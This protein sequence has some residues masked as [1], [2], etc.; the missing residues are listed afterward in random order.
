M[1]GPRTGLRHSYP[2]STRFRLST[3]ALN[4]TRSSYRY[5]YRPCCR[6]GLR[7]CARSGLRSSRRNSRRTCSRTGLQFCTCP[8][9]PATR[10][11]TPGSLEHLVTLLGLHRAAG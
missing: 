1:L 6:N 4:R 9:F 7:A 11:S 10:H 3:C 2:N 8:A 5:G